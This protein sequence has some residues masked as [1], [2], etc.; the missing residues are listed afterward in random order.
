MNQIGLIGLGTMG[1]ALAR[2]LASKNYKTAV[3]N[4]T[5]SRTEE[6]TTLH[7]N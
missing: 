7:G 1:A 6:F 4:R 3:F 5:Y 2:N